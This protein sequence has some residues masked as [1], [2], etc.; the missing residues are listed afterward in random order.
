[1]IIWYLRVYCNDCTQ[2]KIHPIIPFQPVTI[3]QIAAAKEHEDR[4]EEI[5]N[6]DVTFICNPRVHCLYRE[7]FLRVFF[8][9]KN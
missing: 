2:G 9:S 8:Y 6:R 5:I 3:K 7:I 1:M 4:K